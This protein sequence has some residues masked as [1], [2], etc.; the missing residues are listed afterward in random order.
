MLTGDRE[1]VHHRLLHAG[2]SHRA[3]VLTLY[4]LMLLFAI[5]ALLTMEAP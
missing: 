1:H 4:S 3:A 2:L 5:V